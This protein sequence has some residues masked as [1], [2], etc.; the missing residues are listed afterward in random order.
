M[1]TEELMELGLSKEQASKILAMNGRD[2][3]RVKEAQLQQRME[4][5]EVKKTLEE[6]N[7]ELGEYRG[8]DVDGLKSEAK[9]WREKAERAAKEGKEKLDRLRMQEEMQRIC[10]ENGAKDAKVLE[11]LIDFNSVSVCDEKVMGL[12]E[13]VKALKEN[14]SFLF[15]P[16]EALPCFS[17]KINGI[18]KDDNGDLR[19][20]MGL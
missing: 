11:H 4:F 8:L 1:K 16:K 10:K 14:Y 7:R 20:A 18:A 13:Q 19:R 17:Q 9:D 15:E 3:E 2:I 6:R 12:E 5:A